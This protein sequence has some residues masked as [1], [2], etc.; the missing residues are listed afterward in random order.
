[1]RFG[2]VRGEHPALTVSSSSA[3]LRHVRRVEAGI[4]GY[5]TPSGPRQKGA[6]SKRATRLALRVVMTREPYSV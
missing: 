6:P 5:L 2:K 3:M 1:M 4:C